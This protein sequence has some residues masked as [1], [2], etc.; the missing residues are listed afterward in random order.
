MFSPII[1]YTSF[2]FLFFFLMIRRPPR[3]TLFPYTT[4]FRL[5]RLREPGT[6]PALRRL[7][8]EVAEELDGL[9]DG[10]A[11]VGEE[12][13]RALR[14][15]VAHELPARVQHRPRDR[16]GPTDHVGAYGPGRADLSPSH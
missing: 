5:P 7:A 6:E 10:G 13:H 1:S 8:G 9:T 14:D 11:L 16:L 12:V 15:A 3:S 2:F 4:L